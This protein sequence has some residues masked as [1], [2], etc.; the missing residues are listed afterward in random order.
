MNHEEI[1][2][3]NKKA[4]DRNVEIGNRWT[5]PLSK[6]EIDK[7]REGDFKILLSPSIPIPFEWIKDLK[8]KKVLNLAGGGGQQSPLL[9]A[10]GCEVSVADL[11][12][13][14]LKRDQE[15]AM[16]H[17]L[18]IDCINTSADDLSMFENE[19]FDAIINPCSNCFFPEVIPVWQECARVLKPNGSLMT[20]INNPIAYIFD[21]D[22][23]QKKVFTAK[24]PL[25]YSDLES[26]DEEE[27]KKYLG[28]E[29]PYEFSHSLTDQIGEFLKAG[30]VMTDFFEDQWDNEEALEKFFPQFLVY[31]GKKIVDTP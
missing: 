16:E 8:G 2:R 24:Y 9:A 19:S 10:Y 15:S 31:R 22:L 11:S 5:I 18:E 28:I 12:P 3:F 26:L 13:L 23:Q 30:F 20:C 25:P 4:W 14:Q 6:E 29:S 27:K 21:L 1:L 7:A 17:S